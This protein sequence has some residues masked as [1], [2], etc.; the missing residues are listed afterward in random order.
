MKAVHLFYFK[1]HIL[2]TIYRELIRALQ[3]CWQSDTSFIHAFS[4]P[5]G[6]TVARID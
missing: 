2:C 1:Y 4:L 3:I 5:L 6:T